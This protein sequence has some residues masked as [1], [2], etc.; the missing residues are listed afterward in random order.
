M[1]VV[2][3]DTTIIESMWIIE[4]EKRS[5]LADKKVLLLIVR[6]RISYLH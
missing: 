3:L 1:R 5:R 4:L 6:S 2:A